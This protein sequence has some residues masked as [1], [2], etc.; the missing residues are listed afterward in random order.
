MDPITIIAAITAASTLIEKGI[1]IME[2]RKR[3]AEL[4][5]AEEAAWDKFVAEQLQKPHWKL[6]Q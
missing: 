5:P 6:S 3:H 2:E 1:Q 4:T